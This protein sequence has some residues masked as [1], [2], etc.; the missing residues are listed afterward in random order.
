[1]TNIPI[2]KTILATLAFAFSNWKKLLEASIFPILLALPFLPELV[3]LLSMLK[4][5]SEMPENISFHFQVSSGHYVV[6][7]RHSLK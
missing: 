1:M 5:G 4:P 3:H 2:Q 6:E 7:S